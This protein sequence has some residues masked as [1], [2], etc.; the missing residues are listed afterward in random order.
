MS[1]C[2]ERIKVVV[3]WLGEIVVILAD[4]GDGRD[5]A[6]VVPLLHPVTGRGLVVSKCVAVVT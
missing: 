5:E 1:L 2:P 4:G 6:N 3:G